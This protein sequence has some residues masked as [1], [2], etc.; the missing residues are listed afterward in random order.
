MQEIQIL[1]VQTQTVVA[2]L[3]L[4]LVATL[5]LC[6]GWLAVALARH[7]C[8]PAWRGLSALTAR[9]TI[10]L[11]LLWLTVLAVAW[12]PLLERTGNV[13]GP[14]V[15]GLVAI[16]LVADAV[17][18]RQVFA[19]PSGYTSALS[20]RPW[21]F[22]QA[23]G[24]VLTA[25]GFSVAVAVVLLALAWMA[26]PV[27]AVLIDGRY[28]VTHWS[29]MLGG[30]A[31]LRGLLA[32]V[33]GA[34]VLLAAL[35]LWVS[36]SDRATVLALP[37]GWQRCMAGLG[38]AGLLGLLWLLSR[39]VGMQLNPVT[40]TTQ[41]FYE[42]LLNG[43]GNGA[44]RATF[45]LWLAALAGLLASLGVAAGAGHGASP[46]RL[47]AV[48]RQLTV[49]G[50]PVLW[51]LVCWQLFAMPLRARVADLPVADLASMQ[52]VAVLAFGLLLVAAV[53]LAALWVL[54][55]F[56]SRLAELAGLAPQAEA[57]FQTQVPHPD[58]AE[59]AN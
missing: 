58:Q 35:A 52:P 16:M 46:S 34:L 28:Q 42:A 44:L 30:E 24:A 2:Q 5:G 18:Q 29:D 31:F 20:Q 10:V 39:T 11:G 54:W 56:F 26:E 8:A 41:T 40:Q 59:V 47:G 27:G 15:A 23:T 9:A 7:T 49:I 51:L 4:Q 25:I 22:L 14:L 50:A 38:V 57:A 32:T 37:A 19:T 13:L 21:S 55:R 45:V 48:M 36:Q 12:P 1:L 53:V 6:V 33:F 43:P 17:A 3:A